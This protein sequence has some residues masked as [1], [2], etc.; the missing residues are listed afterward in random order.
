[1]KS[2]PSLLFGAL[3]CAISFGAHRVVLAWAERSFPAIA[4]RRRPILVACGA[5]AVSPFLSR[6][7]T[8]RTQSPLAGIAFGMSMFELLIV[9]TAVVPLLVLMGL[10]EIAEMRRRSAAPAAA[11][12]DAAPVVTRRRAMEAI[13]GTAVLGAA[14]AAFGWGMTIGRHGYE[15]RE[16]EVR[17]PGLPKAL[18]GYVIAQISDVHAGLFVGDR[19]L[20]EG[21]ELIRKLRPDIV[22]ATGDLVD[23]D[24]RQAAPLARALADLAP[25]DGVFAVLGNHDYYAGHEAVSAAIRGAGITLLV[26]DARVLR[27]GFALVGV[28][29]AWSQRYGGPGPRLRPATA[30]LPRDL[31]RILLAHQPDTFETSAGR[32]ALQLSGHTHG[33]Q[34]RPANLFMRGP[35]AGRYERDGSVLYV[36]RGFGVAGPPARIGVPPEITKVILVAS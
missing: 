11:L 24:P 35:I 21:A 23:F 32:V 34:I 36:N 22:V 26:N 16:I 31:P 30:S 10:S 6:L 27:E 5:L 14:G 3:S 13:G 2:F 28:D 15:V 20:A 9:L 1:M 8:M 29:D 25:R 17:I 12:D 7:L 33:G 18:E 19:E 4:T